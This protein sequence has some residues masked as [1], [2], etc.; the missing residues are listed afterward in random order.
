MRPARPPEEVDTPAYRGPER[1]LGKH[2]AYGDELFRVM[3]EMLARQ[4]RIEAL[5]NGL[6]VPR[7]VVLHVK[8]REEQP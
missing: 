2:S 3:R 7:R 8:Q 1:R 5:V 4:E 6:D